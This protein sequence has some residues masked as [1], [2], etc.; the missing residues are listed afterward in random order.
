MKKKGVRLMVGVVLA[1]LLTGMLGVYSASGCTGMGLTYRLGDWGGVRYSAQSG[2]GA[3]L[4]FN[5][6]DYAYEDAKD[7]YLSFQPAV[8]YRFQRSSGTS[9]Y[10]GIGY[11]SYANNWTGGFMRE[12]G[13]R[14]LVGMEHFL[15]DKLSV[16]LRATAAF[17]TWDEM[18][19]SVEAKGTYTSIYIDMGISVYR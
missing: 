8:L 1:C 5:Y 7:T 11:L 9:P 19:G 6:G 17:N 13:L 3:E 12:S 10:V 14:I 4:L 18:F 2:F 15:N 16:D